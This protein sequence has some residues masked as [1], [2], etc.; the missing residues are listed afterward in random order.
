MSFRISSKRKKYRS[1]SH[2]S[3]KLPLAIVL[4]IVIVIVIMAFYMFSLNDSSSPNTP[5]GDKVLLQTSMGYIT[6]QLRDDRPIT[7]NN[8]KNLVQQG[9]YDGTIFHRVIA[10][11]M[12]QGGDP[13]GTGFGD[14]SI[15]IIK[16]ELH[17][18]NQNNRGT[19]SMANTGQ[20]NSG[21][22]QF[23][24]NVLN[25]NNLDTKHSVF[26]N[27]TSGMDVVDEISKVSTDSNDRPL[28]EVTLIK[29]EIIS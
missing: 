3:R 7:T 17:G 14:P 25:N 24:I 15:P 6:I 19:I 10:D 18:D 5:K 21:S 22:S 11:F 23:F 12:I 26:G 4:L 27:V 9:V 20:P 28:I 2:K 13:T 16:D 8:F 29:A 1:K